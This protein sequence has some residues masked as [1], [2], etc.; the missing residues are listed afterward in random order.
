M[1]SLFLTSWRF[2]STL[3]FRIVV[4]AVAASVLS[5][6]GTAALLIRNTQQSIQGVVLDAAADDRERAAAML[7]SKVSILRDALAATARQVPSDAWSDAALMGRHLLDKPALG[8]MF[9]SL[10][11]VAPNGQTL[12]RAEGGKLSV[13]LPNIAD[14]DYFQQAAATDQ[15]V[16][17]E[18]VWAKVLK[19]PAVIFA[20]PVV[21][22]DGHLVGVLAGSV[23]VNS[24]SLFSE[25][26]ANTQSTGAVD[27]IVDR[28]GRV[29]AH[30]DATRV[31]TPAEGEPGLQDVVR[32]WLA[33][34]SPIDTVG[35]A[36]VEGTYVVSRTG[37]PL[38]DWVSI[39]VTPA[40]VAFAPVVE[41][42]ATVLPAAVLAGLAAGL[43]A[44]VLAYA[45][46]RPISRLQA[47]AVSLLAEDANFTGWP[48]D[49]GELGELANAFR[50][51]VEQRE[52][53]QTEVQ[54]LLQQIEAVLDH[55]EVGIALTRNG[56]FELV[57]R[58][59]CQ[60]FRCDKV[61]AVGEA[62]R[63]IYAS[64][65]AFV[66]LAKQAQP[67]FVQHGAFDAELELIRR[68]GQ[69]FWARMRGRAVVPGDLGQGTIWTVEDVT[70]A[71]EQ[72]E[73]LTYAST[74]DALTGLVNRV[75]FEDV[76]ERAAVTPETE[77]FCALF[78][79]LDR[80]KQVN[81]TGGHAAGDALLR[82]I[83]QVLRQQVRRSDVVARL[84]GD[85]FAVLL[86]AC[87]RAQAMAIADKM[88]AAVNDYALDWGGARHTV[89]A[90]V[91][92]VAVNGGPTTA[93]DVLRAA[94][95]ACYEAKRRGRN[96]V[97]V[98]Q[99]S[100]FD[101]QPAL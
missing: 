98:F 71:K 44:G 37:I 22:H 67:A 86:P 101:L 76:L 4:L 93:A 72:R 5:A 12:S 87:P 94:D 91:G 78:I 55:A 42:R 81:D 46:T 69:V 59:F 18:V 34:G 17:S 56:R 13:E 1:H 95:S 38:T 14:R 41:A 60:I 83:A 74:H 79:D 48:T 20:V 33:S 75:A 11:A 39:R 80:F 73:R 84:G 70:A 88:C 2:A 89:G 85:E 50:H 77:P 92:L 15:P 61:D 43:L 58:Q 9:A 97:E 8:T 82:D 63:M 10:Y 40:A 49:S 16:I 6:A 47:R 57:S 51:V 65:E 64:D 29:I 24:T 32:T 21:G 45:M 31:M 30:P 35:Q 54:A 7:S 66:A 23:A 27:L 62:T 3:K 99:P 90:S 25:V 100:G 19:R 68:S 53:R 28:E 36:T 96:R 26:R 52:R